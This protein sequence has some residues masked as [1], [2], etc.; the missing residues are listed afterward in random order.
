[1]HSN[2]EKL[3][4]GDQ[5]IPQYFA[6]AKAQWTSLLE[7]IS[8]VDVSELANKLTHAQSWFEHHCG[9]RWYGQ[10]VMVWTGFASIYS[11]RDG[12]QRPALG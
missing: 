7:D 8:T 9:G 1:M 11:T 2:I 10:E 4:A 12:Y 5:N 3:M 6:A